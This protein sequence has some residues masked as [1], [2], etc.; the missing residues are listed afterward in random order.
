[1]GVWLAPTTLAATPATAQ[2]QAAARLEALG[3]G[4]LWGGERIGSRE[5]FAQHTILLAATE[6]LVIGIGVAN[7]WMRRGIAVQAG[8]ATLAEA[9]PNRFM[10]G[11]GVS[12]DHQVER[13]GLKWERPVQQMR[14]YLDEMD[15]AALKF[16]ELAQPAFP[17]ILAALGPKMLELARNRAGGALT[18]LSPVKHT[19]AA[20]KLLGPDKLL[21]VHQAVVLEPDPAQARALARENLTSGQTASTVYGKNFLRLGY[22]DHDVADGCSNRLIDDI[23]AWGDEPAIARRIQG[24]LDAGADHVLLHPITSDR[25]MVQPDPHDVSAAV[26]QLERLAPALP[27][28]TS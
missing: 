2:R 27:L 6:S 16:P 20:R 3:L 13:I 12:H 4:S 11:V 8:A 5:T 9:Y 26:T 18:F 7:M 17:F 19:A 15:A 1:V 22:T 21:I 24:H 14:E 23:V 10:L 28:T 25:L